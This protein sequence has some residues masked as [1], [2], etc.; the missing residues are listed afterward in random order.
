MQ[1]D[2]VRGKISKPEQCSQLISTIR[3][4]ME[5]Q[6]ETGTLYL[7]YP[8]TANA[9]EAITVE[10]LWVTKNKGMVAFIFGDSQDSVLQLKEQQDSLY[11][12]MDFYLKKYS[13]LRKGRSL[14]FDPLV[15]TVVP[16]E[17]SYSDENNEY[18][19]CRNEEI[20]SHMEKFDGFDKTFYKRLCEVLQKVSEIKP[21]KKRTNVKK[22]DSYGAIIKKIEKE[23][24]NLDQWQKKAAFEMPE[25]PQRIKGLAGS[26]K[27]IVLALKA[28]YLHT[29]FPELKIGVTYYTRAL[30]QQYINLISDF[31]QDMS[32]EKVNWDNLDVIHAWG[33]NSEQG[34]YSNMA[35]KAGFKAYNLTSAISKFGRGNPFKG[36]CDELLSVLTTEYEPEYDVML[37]DE[38]Q[39][40]PSSF[41]RLIYSNVKEP[42]RIIWAYDELQNLSNV[43]MPSLEE[44]F[45]ID[46]TGS[47][48][49]NIENRDDE[50]RRDIT[51]PVCYRNPPWTLALAHALGFGLYHKPIIQM[52]DNLKVWQD[53]GYTVRSGRL[54]ENN[55][56]QLSRKN[57]STPEY[58]EELLN[59]DDSINLNKFDTKEAQYSWIA[60]EIKKNI[61][62][63]E[64]DP[65]DILVIF[66]DTYSAK[67]EY[68]ELQ[69]FLNMRG[70]K[71][72]LAGVDTDRDTFRVNGC[73]T[74]AHV[75]R[76]KGNEAPMVYVVNADY[77]AEGMELIKLR[78]IL[79]TSITRSRAWVRIC[80]VGENMGQIEKEYND[81]VDN[82]FDL[83]FRIPTADE[84]KETRRVNRERTSK[85]KQLVEDAKTNINELIMQIEQGTV[86]PELIPE[87]GKLKNLLEKK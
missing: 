4:Y 82:K 86:D 80:G 60:S 52:F 71:S 85:E 1:F 29:Q 33:S 12:N 81:C 35:Q 5:D 74:C 31:V 25:G 50:P 51:L 18:I 30:Y 44:M 23:I 63:D 40:M 2:V 20:A 6:D 62:D 8:L 53:I 57:V 49:I 9:D 43:E 64:L 15:I 84:L 42:K 54:K 16:N 72:I 47:L 7:G 39:D 70:I 26:G 41:F 59:K 46:E 77:C 45:G 13:S 73:I 10:A 67:R 76:A 66:P 19:I 17:L 68:K 65:D 37:I 22:I 27:T 58:F 69:I 32:G 56:V 55:T 36:C 79:F 14:A 28:A 11:Y 48:N 75:Y 3:Q 38:A 34:V 87:L 21:R 24:A 61:V 83:R 78:N